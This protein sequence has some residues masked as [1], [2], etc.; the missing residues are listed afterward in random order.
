M[1]RPRKGRMVCCVPEHKLFGPLNKK[2]LDNQSII[3]TVDEYEIIRLI[4]VEG[5]TQ[6][7]CAQRMLVARATIQ[8]SYQKARNKIGKALVNGF[9]LQI[10]GGDFQL[11]D[12]DQRSLYGCG[13]H[14]RNRFNRR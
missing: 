5:L 9:V 14:Q 11:Y 8:T 12:D 4:D 2:R 13:R 10:E 3:M 1:P 7:E 6:A